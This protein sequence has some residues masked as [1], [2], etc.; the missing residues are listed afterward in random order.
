MLV[1]HDLLLLLLDDESGRISAM[2]SEPD[3]ALAGAV[4]VDLT[5]RGLVGIAEEGETVKKGRLVMRSSEAPAEPVLSH[6]VDVVREREGSKPESA[7]GPLAKGLRDQLA[8]DLVAA[9]VLR[10]EEHKALGLFRTTRLPADDTSYEDELR[11]RLSRVLT[12]AEEPDER[13]GPLIALLFAMDGLMRVLDIE[14]KKAAKR[15]AR[16]VAEGDWAASAVRS[17]VQAMQT[18]VIVTVTAAS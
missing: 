2:L 3:K 16:Q 5:A 9:G 4:L 13:T 8:D 17:A 18:A 11:E 12:G 7:L 6:A 15:R 10:R 1:A 14:D